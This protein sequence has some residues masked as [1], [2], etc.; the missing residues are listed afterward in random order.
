MLLLEI[1]KTT[2][3]PKKEQRICDTLE[4]AVLQ[5]CFPG[6]VTMSWVM[7]NNSGNWSF[8]RKLPR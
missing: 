1:A 8:N 6:I 7:M 4:N 2:V 3:G 5:W